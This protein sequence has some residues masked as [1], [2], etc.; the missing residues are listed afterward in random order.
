MDGLVRDIPETREIRSKSTT[1]PPPFRRAACVVGAEWDEPQRIRSVQITFDSGFKRELMLT[2]Q[3]SRTRNI[4]RA[5]QPETVR[6]YKVS[7]GDRVLAT[8]ANNHQRVNR[9]RFQ[10]VETKSVRIAI[11]ATN[12]IDQAHVFE[13]RCYA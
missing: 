6:D 5:P 9:V 7:A 4:V 11:S 8:V 3:D 10:P 1:G 13:V 12:G 2:A